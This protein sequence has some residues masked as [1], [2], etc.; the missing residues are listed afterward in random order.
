MS[1]YKKI[2]SNHKHILPFPNSA[3]VASMPKFVHAIV[4]M[5]GSASYEYPSLGIP[6]FQGCE[7]ICSGRGFTI[8]PESKTEY[9][10]L[11]QKIE[12]ISKL[13]KDQIDKAKI[14]AFIYTVLTRIK[15]N[16]I[17]PFGRGPMDDKNFWSKMSKLIDN[18]NEEED[19][20]KKMMKMQ[21]KNN[22][23]HTINYN[24]LK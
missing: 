20:L 16:L 11:L 24:L 6:V 2:C 19:L 5:G 23:R 7:S 22:D 18:Y 3:S 4:T 9:L 15:V 17:T 14:Y 10:D 21:E 12:K 1:V 13:N 8:D